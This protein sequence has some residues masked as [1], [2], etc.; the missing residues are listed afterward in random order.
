MGNYKIWVSLG[1]PAS[2]TLSVRY[3]CGFFYAE[4][5]D[6]IPSTSITMSA[7]GLNVAGYDD[8]GCGG[9]TGDQDTASDVLII[10][11]G[12]TS[13]IIEGV[14]PFGVSSTYYNFSQ[15]IRVNGTLRSDGDQFT[16]GGTQV[17][18]N[19]PLAGNSGCDV[20]YSDCN[21]FD[22]CGGY[23]QGC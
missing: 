2:A 5:S 4:L 20:Y 12:N 6:A 21:T 9:I 16:I 19:Y 7:T 23:G 13:N 10:S 18:I 8:G 22:P 15:Q 3:E 1:D 11:A 17:T 14:T